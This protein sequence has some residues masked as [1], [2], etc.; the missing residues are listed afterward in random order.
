MKILLTGAAGSLGGAVWGQLLAAGHE[1]VPVDIRANPTRPDL[2]IADLCVV[3]QIQPLLDGVDAVCHLGS[4]PYITGDLRAFTAG[5]A[6]NVNG[7]FN[8]LFAAVQHGIR[9]FVYASSIQ[10]YGCLTSRTDEWRRWINPP[11]YLPLDEELPLRPVDIYPWTKASGEWLGQSL[12]AAYA[13]MSF[14]AL[15][16]TA[17]VRSGRSLGD[18][19]ARVSGWRTPV[20]TL[21]TYVA[22]DDAARAVCLSLEANLPGYVPLN[23]TSSTASSPWSPEAITEA[24]GFLPAFTRE[25]GPGDSLLCPLK[26]KRLLGFWADGLPQ[27]APAQ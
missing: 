19:Q 8:I 11:D 17:I 22:V 3:E 9:R 24:W 7:N 10:A 15:R 4:K 14:T 6:N 12:C 1:V 2:R 27:A 18:L 23:V 16:F 20:V 26:A 21:W 13:D 5:F 25:L